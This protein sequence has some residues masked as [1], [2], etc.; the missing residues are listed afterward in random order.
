VT[1]EKLLIPLRVP[2][3][4]PFMGKVVTGS[5]AIPGGLQ[6]DAYRHRLATRVFEAAGEARR[7]AGREERQ[8]AVGAIGRA[9]WLE[10]WEEAVRGVAT[11]VAERA[12]RRLDAEARAAR[13]PRRMRKRLLPD[14]GE[15][16]AIAARLG[17]AG[18]A[19][20]PALDQIEVRGEAALQ[21]TALEREAVE[22]WQDALRMSA[23]RLEAAWLDL[24][25]AAVAETLRWARTANNVSRWRKPLWPV[26]VVTL[27]GL[28]FAGWLGLVLGGQL[29]APDWFS[30]IWQQVFGQ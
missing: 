25:D 19:L 30:G 16:R 4:G 29:Q 20:V 23:R 12:A 26:A 2:E 7:L 1:N 3:L 22:V 13:L 28:A 21:A 15:Q 24:E 11:L 10:A 14:V 18:A 17:S 5:G 8:A 6:L 9:A 27:A